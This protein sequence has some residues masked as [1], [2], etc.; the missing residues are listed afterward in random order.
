[1]QTDPGVGGGDDGIVDGGLPSD[2][3]LSGL[4]ML[5]P[6]MGGALGSLPSALG[7]AIPS[8]GGGLGGGGLGDLGE[9]IGSALHDPGHDSAE[10]ASDEHADPLKDQSGSGTDNSKD[11]S[12]TAG[13]NNQGNGSGATNAE[14]A[15]NGSAAPP[16]A[17]A[18]PGQA[19][20]PSTQVQLPDNSVRTAATPALAQAGRAVLNGDDID[21][22]FTAARLQLPPMGSAVNEPVSPSRLQFGDIGQYTDHRVM[23]LGKDSVWLNGQVTPI[24]QLEIGPNFLGWTHASAAATPTAVAATTSVAPTAPPPPAAS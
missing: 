24:D 16:P 6:A 12:Q 13:S 15:G 17:A 7:S 2:P 11:G 23:A 21:D 4:G 18:A 8:L 20:S 22:A 3:L 9:A 5:G 1:A 19:P 14:N 10:Q